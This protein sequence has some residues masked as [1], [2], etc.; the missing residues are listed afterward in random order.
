MLAIGTKVYVY[1][2]PC[3]FKGVIL[4]QKQIT[5]TIVFYTVKRLDLND[6]HDYNQH[7]VF[8]NK[9]NLVNEILRDIDLLQ[10]QIADVKRED[11]VNDN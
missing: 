3:L 5:D 6:E 1:D 4:K 9:E 10:N 11:Y 8:T 2:A 7:Q